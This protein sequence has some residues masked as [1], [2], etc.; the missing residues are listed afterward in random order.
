[1]YHRS[2]EEINSCEHKID[3]NV[4]VNALRMVRSKT[5]HFILDQM[6]ACPRRTFP[7]E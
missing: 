7:Q 4:E 3:I 5:R 2:R 6:F 1:M